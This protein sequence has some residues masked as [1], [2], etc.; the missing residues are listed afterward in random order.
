M[1]ENLKEID[2]IKLTKF[3]EEEMDKEFNTLKAFEEYLIE[4]LKTSQI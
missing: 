4:K 2:L 1:E 3:N